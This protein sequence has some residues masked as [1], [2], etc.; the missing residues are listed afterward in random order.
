MIYPKFL[1][2]NDVI[3]ICAPSCGI[4]EEEEDYKNSIENIQKRDY[5]IYETDSVHNSGDVSNT[6]MIRAREFMELISNPEISC[7]ICATGG[8]FLTDILPYI[9]FS[10]I[11]SNPKWVMG[12]S[13]PTNLL[14]VITTSFDIATIYGHNAGSFD[15]DK[16]FISQEIAFD[17]LE[18]NIMKQYSYPFYEKNR[19]LRVNGTYALTEESHWLCNYDKIT[20][21]GR[22]IGGCLDCLRYLPGT[23]YDSTKRFVEKY[24]NE[25][26]IWYFDVFSLSTEDFYLSLFQLKEAGWFSYVKGVIM[27]RVLYPNS[28]TSMTYEKALH[29]IF[30]NIPIIM[31]ADIGHVAPKMT[32]MNGCIA[33]VSYENHIGSI[34]QF[35]K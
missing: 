3:G 1:K 15:S 25:G 7:V 29:K 27:G 34:E 28:H 23:S 19:E 8:D 11:S 10:K 33:T 2:K 14:Y 24:Q 6:A 12:A 18:G 4:G 5:S 22:I 20:F 16:L 21:T 17:F 9:D 35:L 13:D 31:D 26:I 30:G 32:I